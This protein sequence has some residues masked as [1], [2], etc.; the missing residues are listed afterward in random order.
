MDDYLKFLEEVFGQ[1]GHISARKMFGGHGVYHQGVMFALIADGVLFLKVDDGNR[2]F[3]EQEGLPP[4]EYDKGNKT[5]VMSYC[6]APDEML[7]DP[8]LAAQWA[9]RSYQ[10]A[11]QSRAAN[12]G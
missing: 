2:H 4:F 1:F 12:K 9:Q 6:Q 8:E 7:E 10:A 5:V 11:M 3:F